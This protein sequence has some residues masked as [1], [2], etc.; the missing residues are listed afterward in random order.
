M[1]FRDIHPMKAQF[2]APFTQLQQARGYDHNYVI[3]GPQGCLRPAAIAGSD[4]SGITLQV[5]TTMP[6]MHFYTANYIH[7]GLVGKGGCIYGPQHAFC[8]ETQFYPDAIHHPQFPSP[9][10][11]ASEIYDHKTILTFTV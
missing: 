1:D 6:G 10:L 5:E 3:N 4:V 11:K 9:I 8:L 7:D 2:N